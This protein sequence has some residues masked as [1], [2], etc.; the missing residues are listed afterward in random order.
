MTMES[1]ERF[2]SLLERHRGIV[3]KVAHT[4]AFGADDRADLAQEIAAQLWHAWPRYEAARSFSTWMYRIALNVAISHVRDAGRRGR[5]WVPLDDTLHDLADDN[6][7]DPE[8]AQRVRALY[9]FIARLA[10]LDR[11]LMLLYLENHSGREIADVLG[12]GESNVTTK[13]SRLKQ[14]IRDEI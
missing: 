7:T 6:A 5:H 12:I 10:P 1:R 4:Y 13:I 8:A 2:A 11:A 14:R 3:M 9:G